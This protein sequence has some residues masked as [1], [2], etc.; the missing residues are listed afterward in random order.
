MGLQR[1]LGMVNLY[2]RSIPKAA[3][4]QMSLIQ[5]TTNSKKNHRTPIE[6]TPEAEEAFDKC[7]KGLADAALL[8]HPSAKAKIRLVTD[9]SDTAMG[10]A[11]EQES[12]DGF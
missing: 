5:Y 12:E 8:V 1:F 10:A 6:W 11:I 9:A 3:E 7:K 4:A 2:R